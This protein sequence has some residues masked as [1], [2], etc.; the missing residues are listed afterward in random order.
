MLDLASCICLSLG[1]IL[2]AADTVDGLWQQIDHANIC[3]KPQAKAIGQMIW[4]RGVTGFRSHQEGPVC[5]EF[6][7]GSTAGSPLL[8]NKSCKRHG[9]F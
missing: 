8:H 5:L 2:C 9:I 3:A 4:R 1:I 6:E 7:A